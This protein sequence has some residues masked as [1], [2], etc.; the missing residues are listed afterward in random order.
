MKVVQLL[1]I[2]C[3]RS[4]KKPLS[5]F[6]QS[7]LNQSLISN[8]QNLLISFRKKRKMFGKEWIG[9]S[10]ECLIFARSYKVDKMKTSFKNRIQLTKL[11][12]L[13]HYL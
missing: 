12:T 9:N 10:K 8:E 5:I 3:K 4:T 1:Y 11:L 7:H 13:N 2:R 6:F